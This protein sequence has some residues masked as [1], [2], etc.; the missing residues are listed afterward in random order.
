M[1]RTFKRPD[2]TEET[3]EGTAEELAEYERKLNQQNEQQ[4]PGKP[5]ILKGKELEALIK[6]TIGPWQVP[7]S[8]LIWLVSCP[9]CQRGSCD[10]SNHFL[11]PQANPG[12]TF[13]HRL[14]LGAAEIAVG[15]GL[16]AS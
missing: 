14:E 12:N 9:I 1:K 6:R 4:Q 16:K 2:G 15:L 8:S 7:F 13:T 3:L 5:G 10:G 11:Y